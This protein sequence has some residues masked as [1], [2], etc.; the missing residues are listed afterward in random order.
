[1]SQ[2]SLVGNTF[3]YDREA[4]EIVL[5][6]VWKGSYEVTEADGIGYDV[7][8]KFSAPEIAEE[9]ELYVFGWMGGEWLL[10]DRHRDSVLRVYSYTFDVSPNGRLAVYEDGE[11]IGEMAVPNTHRI[12]DEF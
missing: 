7:D 5:T 2:M 10:Q 3:R 9:H 12:Q 6:G 8:F 1:M 11:I 4:D